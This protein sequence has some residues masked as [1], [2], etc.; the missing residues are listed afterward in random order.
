MNMSFTA[1]SSY[2]L[3][4]YHHNESKSNVQDKFFDNLK[5]CNGS[6]VQIWKQFISTVPNFTK[7]DIPT[8][9]KDTKEAA[10]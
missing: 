1:T 8:V 3:L 2:L 9:L 10:M 6:N 7:T 4:P 5:S